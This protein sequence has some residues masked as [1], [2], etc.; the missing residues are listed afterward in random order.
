MDNIGRNDLCF[1]GSGKKY[2]KCCMSKNNNFNTN[3]R[4]AQYS[5][6]Y[7]VIKEDF[8]KNGI[9]IEKPGFYNDRNF[10]EIEKGYSS[11][12]NNYARYIQTKEYTEEYIKKARKEISLIA[13]ILHSEL[14]KDGRRGACIDVAMVFSKILEME[15]YW[16]YIAKGSLTMEYPP[17]SNIPKGYFWHYDIKSD[18]SAGHA[19]VVAP[20]FSVIDITIK[21]QIYT[22][23]Q[24]KYLPD[25]VL[26]DNMQRVTAEVKD[27]FSPEAR[28][29]L[30]CQGVKESQ[31][32]QY[33]STEASNI[34]E[35]FP[36]LA[37]KCEK[38]LLNY[39]TI[40]FGAPTEELENIK[41]LNLNGMYGLDIY[42]ELIVPELKKIRQNA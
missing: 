21:Q 3:I 1:C 16:N 28:Y 2:K 40:A 5:S 7:E 25:L 30:K 23:G 24:E 38:S 26:G 14:V 34:L 42:K 35:L 6:N 41:S 37:I 22:K 9:S 8:I 4:I 39:I 17:E 20:P 36:S 27:V 10:L 19:W 33:A 31:M 32:L 11:Y 15:G 18:I 13:S 29:F 12:L